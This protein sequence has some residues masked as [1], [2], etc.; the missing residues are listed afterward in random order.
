[1][2]K[3]ETQNDVYLEKSGEIATLFFNCC[4]IASIV[5]LFF[6]IKVASFLL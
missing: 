3:N 2:A 4:G 5:V 6:D 1:M